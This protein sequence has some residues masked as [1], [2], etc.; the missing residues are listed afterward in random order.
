MRSGADWTRLVLGSEGVLGAITHV[1]FKVRKAPAHR[2]M[3]GILMPSVA[4][5]L[6]AMEAMFYAGHRPAVLRLYDPL[7]SL[8][9][10]GKSGGCAQPELGT[11]STLIHSDSDP[12]SA[13]A[14][15]RERFSRGVLGEM[16]GALKSKAMIF[17][18]SH[19][20]LLNF[21]Q[22]KAGASA[23]MILGCEG[24]DQENTR[25]EAQACLELAK[26]L[27]GV[28]RGAGPGEHWLAHRH[29]ISFKLSPMLAAGAFVDT[30]EVAAR[31]D[32]ILP[33]YLEVRA[34]LRDRAFI[35]A[36]FS[37][38][39]E[40][41]ASIYFTFAGAAPTLA[42][43]EAGYD[44]C[45]SLALASVRRCGGTISH[46]HGVGMSKQRFLLDELGE[47]GHA[48]LKAVHA[49]FDPDGICNPG[50][51]TLGEG[52]SLPSLSTPGSRL[53]DPCLRATAAQR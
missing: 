28:D 12:L 29:A 34:A 42:Q 7:D 26:T 22:D 21:A 39:Y 31:W 17:G 23:L 5:G 46:H 3:R 48:L 16:A 36:H 49:S 10:K 9:N 11:G 27:G 15:D 8:I 45:W 30:M 38:G 51:L 24:A 50:K 47:G 14:S 4:S 13:P 35:M 18:L 44:E 43:R 6:K 52:P 1:W 33:M 25:T 37:H 32:R 19:P 40:D 53:V 2:I 41:G 20:R